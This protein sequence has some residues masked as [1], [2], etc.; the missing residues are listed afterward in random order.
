ML[1]RTDHI[2]FNMLIG[3]IY[4]NLEHFQYQETIAVQCIPII[5]TTF[6]WNGVKNSLKE[7]VRRLP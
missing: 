5:V 3:G 7:S 2:K 4:L 6:T 1:Q